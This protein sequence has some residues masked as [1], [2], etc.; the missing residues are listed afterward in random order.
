MSNSTG[1]RDITEKTLAVIKRLL[2][3]MHRT[4]SWA[5]TIYSNGSMLDI[6]SESDTN[7]A[8]CKQNRRST[9]LCRVTVGGSAVYSFSRKQKIIALSNHRLVRLNTMA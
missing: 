3:Y 8:V 2:R 4:R 9:S 1:H 7:W 5:L 6:Y